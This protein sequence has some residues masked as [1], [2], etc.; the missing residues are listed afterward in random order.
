MGN[1]LTTQSV[2]PNAIRSRTTITP[3]T[4]G[5]PGEILA[6]P[7]L[8]VYSFL[9]LNNAT[10]GFNRNMILGAGGFGTVYKGQFGSGMN[11]AIKKLNPQSE[12][13]LR[14]WQVIY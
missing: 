5:T 6:A 8:K 14:E 1:C 12:Q 9:D 3:S 2:D 7:N 13:G 4:P 10:S 11:V